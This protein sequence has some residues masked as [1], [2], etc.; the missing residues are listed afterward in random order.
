MI[1]CLR[2][3]SAMDIGYLMDRGHG[4]HAG[5]AN[6]VSDAP[7]KRW[8]GIRTSGHVN[9]PVTAYRCTVCGYV[10]LRAPLPADE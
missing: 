3:Q 2:C 1:T 10:E 8:Y 9:L 7:E 4:N 6:W 5:T